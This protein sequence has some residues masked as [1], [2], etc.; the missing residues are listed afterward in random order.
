MI[1]TERLLLRPWS[2]DDAEA[3]YELAKDPAVGPS[4]G[5]PVH[6]SVENSRQIIRDVLAVPETYAVVRLSD[7]ALLGSVGLHFRPHKA[8]GVE[9]G[10]YELGYWIGQKYWGNGYAPEAGE[11]LLSHVFDDLRAAV[12]WC[13]H[14]I[15]NAKSKRVIEKLGFRYICR[16]E[17]H[18]TELPKARVSLVYLQSA[19]DFRR[20]LKEKQ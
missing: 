16:D 9:I 6:T 17:E 13:C 10:E 3:L 14:F 7:G 18:R 15:D 12:C 1:Q 5:W 4:A 8:A 11:A 2:E 19:E 20:R